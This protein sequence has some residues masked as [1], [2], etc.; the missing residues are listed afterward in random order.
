LNTPVLFIVFNRPDLTR[1]VF[2]TIRQIQPKRLFVA[3]D[4]P[5]NGNPNDQKACALTRELIRAGVDWD[6]EFRTLYRDRN[7]GCKAAVS[8]A[9]RWFFD[10]V[11]RGIVLEDDCLPDPTFFPFCETL[12]ARYD[13]DPRVMHISGNNF[14][15]GRKRGSASYYCSVYPHIWGWASWRRA[16]IHYDV[17]MKSLPE[18]IRAN[19]MRGITSN[20]DQQKYWLQIFK[21]VHEG[22]I[23][24]W[25][26][27]WTFTVWSLGGLSILPNVNL[28]S[29]IGFDRNATHTQ[30]PSALA[31]L[32]V[33]ALTEIVHPRE[34]GID[35]EA[36]RF[37]FDHV[38]SGK[39]ERARRRA[40]GKRAGK[41][42]GLINALL[43]KSGSD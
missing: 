12:L 15:F 7:L 38:F 2:E 24:T 13:S 8:S 36:D 16:W 14:Q 27:Q 5:R 34:L 22:A 31:D 11:E 19:A 28:V 23:D 18:F 33:A 37:T 30:A 21:R 32:P 26:Y 40:L 10:Q 1:R 6:C 39:I 17:T 41:W 35:R 4:G 9:I 20:K 29:N 42:R 43:R 25:D 3:A